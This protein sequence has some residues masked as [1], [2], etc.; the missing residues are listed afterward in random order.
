MKGPR[1]PRNG[2][3][4]VSITAAKHRELMTT[5]R[6][7]GVSITT[8]IE[9]ALDRQAKPPPPGAAPRRWLF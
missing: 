7:L 3:R 4:S 5:K 9:Q 1:K 6:A 2:P 8:L